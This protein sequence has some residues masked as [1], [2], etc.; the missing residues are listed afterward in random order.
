M[1]RKKKE[2]K[3]YLKFFGGL[4]AVGVVLA[5][6]GNLAVNNQEIRDFSGKGALLAAY[7][8]L[9]IGVLLSTLGSF[10]LAYTFKKLLEEKAG[11]QQLEF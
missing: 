7:A 5:V 8:A 10:G 3:D 11:R 2:M 4:I 6:L 9:G 1:G